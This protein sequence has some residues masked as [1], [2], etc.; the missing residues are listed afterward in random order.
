MIKIFLLQILFLLSMT[1][2]S[3]AYLDPG[4]TN[5]ILQFLALIFAFVLS[6]WIFIKNYLKQIYNKIFKS[7]K[8]EKKDP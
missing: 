8:N 6:G 4:S 3:Q 2:N 7:K 1:S 5:I